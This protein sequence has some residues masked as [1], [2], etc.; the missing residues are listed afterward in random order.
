MLQLLFFAPL[1]GGSPALGH[2]RA[3]LGPVESEVPFDLVLSMHEGNLRA[4]VHNGAKGLDVPEVSCREGEL[5]LGFPHYDSRITAKLSEDGRSLSGDWKRRS[6]RDKWTTL[7]FRAEAG[8]LPRFPPAH[9]PRLYLTDFD[10]QITLGDSVQEGALM[11]HP[12]DSGGVGASVRTKSGDLGYLAGSFDGSHLALSGFDGFFALRFVGERKDSEISGTC[13]MGGATG[14]W[15]GRSGAG[16][17]LG[18]GFAQDAPVPRFP[19][20]DLSYSDLDGVQ[21]ALA[22]PLFEGRPLLISLGGS[23]CPNCQDEMRLLAELDAQYGPKGLAITALCFE[24][25]GDFARDAQQARRMAERSGAK[26]RVLLGG[27]A[28]KGEP[29]RAFPVL[30]SVPAFPTALFVARDG[31]LAA[32]HTGVSGPATGKAHETERAAFEKAIQALLASPAPDSSLTWNALLDGMW[33]DEREG[34]LGTFRRSGEQ[35]SF[36]AEEMTRFDRPTR[37]GIVAE[38][39]V[40]VRGRLARIGATL[41]RYDAGTGTFYDVLD[42][43]HRLVGGVRPHLPMVRGGLVNQA[44]ELQAALVSSDPLLRA[45]TRYHLV[46]AIRSRQAEPGLEPWRGVDDPDPRVAEAAIWA[47]GELGRAELV[48]AIAAKLADPFA[49]VRL[50]AVRALGRLGWEASQPKLQELA[51]HDPDA[52]VRALAKDP[53]KPPARRGPPP[54]AGDK[55]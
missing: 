28:G 32:L 3:A 50:C 53:P 5:V 22:E 14:T 7:A 54:D 20:E 40:L 47:A 15:S 9:L 42:G 26:F 12:L 49:P 25:S 45:E 23:W 16:D 11:I 18:D 8:E 36:Q 55:H 27:T 48:Q 41:L 31:S 52:R 19:L 21:R 13:R 37:E 33:R 30:E 1:L 38:G 29:S 34:W 24:Y 2:W 51:A 39:P 4:E 6:G 17:A 10:I 44:D 43:L 46:Q 35:G